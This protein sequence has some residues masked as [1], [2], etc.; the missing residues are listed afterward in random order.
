M[1]LFLQLGEE[2]E[3][4]SVGILGRKAILDRLALM[5]SMSAT[6]IAMEER[7]GY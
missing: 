1:H 7:D 5:S 3:L 6:S 4:K 2:M